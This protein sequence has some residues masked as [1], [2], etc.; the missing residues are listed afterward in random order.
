M[1]AESQRPRKV[2][3]RHAG[4]REGPPPAARVLRGAGLGSRMAGRDRP[5][6]GARADSSPP[7]VVRTEVLRGQPGGREP[8]EALRAVHG[9]GQEAEQ[10]REAG[11]PQGG[12][13]WEEGPVLDLAV[14]EQQQQQEQQGEQQ[15]ADLQPG[16]AGL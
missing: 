5:E 12:G 7:G 9:K 2:A 1:G 6:S 3:R 4:H 10:Q 8:A 16:G 11:Q 13:Q 15:A 14:P